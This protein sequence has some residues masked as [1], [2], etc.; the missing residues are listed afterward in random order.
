MEVEITVFGQLTFELQR[1]RAPIKL[2]KHSIILKSNYKVVHENFL[3]VKQQNKQTPQVVYMVASDRISP[4]PGR[5]Q[6]TE[7]RIHLVLY[8]LPEALKSNCV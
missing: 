4:A 6:R 7:H 8:K 5:V 1:T 2:N 3:T